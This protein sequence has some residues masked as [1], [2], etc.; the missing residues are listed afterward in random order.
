MAITAEATDPDIGMTSMNGN[1]EGQR[2]NQ[3]KRQPQPAA[4]EQEG[5]PRLEEAFDITNRLAQP[6]QTLAELCTRQPATS[7]EVWQPHTFAAE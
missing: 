4:V 1:E 2:K 5:E 3:G 7:D 6:F